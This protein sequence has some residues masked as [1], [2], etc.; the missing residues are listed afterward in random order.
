MSGALTARISC[1]RLEILGHN[2]NKLV[3]PASNLR[4]SA[5]LG[6]VR[7]KQGSALR[8]LQTPKPWNS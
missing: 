1:S 8:E 2:E 4:V 7:V 5:I 3:E 6:W